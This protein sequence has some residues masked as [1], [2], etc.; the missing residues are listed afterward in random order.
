MTTTFSGSRAFAFGVAIQSDGKIVAAG[1][2]STP[3]SSSSDFALAR[4]QVG[5]LPVITITATG[6]NAAENG[7][8]PGVFTFA[9]SDNMTSAVTVNYSVG[10]TATQG[11]DYSTI[12]NSITIPAGQ[13][14][15]TKIITP[16]LDALV[17]GSETVSL[18]IAPSA[19]YTVGNPHTATV[20]IADYTG[21]KLQVPPSV[22]FGNV[23]VGSF[24][25][26]PLNI[27][28]GSS[29][30]TLVVKVN[31]PTPNPP[32]SIVTGGGTV[33]IGPGLSHQVTLRFT[34]TSAGT[35]MGT[36]IINS[37]DPARPTAS[38]E[39]IGKGR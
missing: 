11:V 10:G 12:G 22:N 20:T 9:R 2:L 17:E 32:F 21:G 5:L 28:N 18:T 23:V 39:L 13:A 26:R 30:Q 7:T 14:T 29:S 31:S 8:N 16:I 34:A 1:S 38:F 24:T 37:S 33:V 27:T 35:A 25:N 36:L 3:S 15:A 4:Y 6:P 19:G